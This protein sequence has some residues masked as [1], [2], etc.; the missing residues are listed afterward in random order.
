MATSLHDSG[1]PRMAQRPGGISKRLGQYDMNQLEGLIGKAAWTGI[2]DICMLP[3]KL[4]VHAH[5]GRGP[6][7]AV[8]RRE[9]FRLREAG[10]VFGT[11]AWEKQPR[12]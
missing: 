8:L 11:A 2:D 3:V 9:N 6:R 7:V 10:Y 4:W 12:C 5:Y 1:A